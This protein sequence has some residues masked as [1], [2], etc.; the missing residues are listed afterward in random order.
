MGKRLEELYA[1][2]AEIMFEIVSCLRN[3]P[4]YIEEYPTDID[5]SYE[6]N[7]LAIRIQDHVPPTTKRFS[8]EMY[9]GYFSTIHKYYN[10][11]W[12]SLINQALQK[13]GRERG[14]LRTYRNAIVFTEF[15]EKG[16]RRRDCDNYALTLIHNSLIRNNVIHDDSFDHMRY[17]HVVSGKIKSERVA[18]SITIIENDRKWEMSK[19]CE[20]CKINRLIIPK[21]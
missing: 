2:H 6:D 4:E 12:Y 16:A 14:A 10:S 8:K 3:E 1:K 17:V 19:L 18:T 20:H 15:H 21:L 13:L 7:V 11:L 9:K 5:V